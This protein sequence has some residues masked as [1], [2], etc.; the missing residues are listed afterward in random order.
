MLCAVACFPL[1]QS[2]VKELVTHHDMSFVQAIWGRYF[3]HLLLVPLFFPRT[4]TTIRDGHHRRIQ[5]IRGLVLF[6]STGFSFLGLRFVPLPE[7]TALTFIAPVI[8]TILAA[9]FLHETVGW[10]RWLAVVIG[11]VG[12]L[13]IIR[14]DVQLEW[15]VL[16]PVG[17]ATT[18]AIYQVLTRMVGVHA[19][20]HE[21][22]FYTALVGAAAASVMVPLVWVW[23][24]ATGWM[25]LVGSAL[26]A[27]LGHWCMIMAYGRAEA[28]FI[29]PFAYTELIWATLLGITL[30]GEIPTTSTWI[31][32]GIIVISGLWIGLRTNQQPNK[33]RLKAD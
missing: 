1:M 14:P 23:P 3:F 18:Y 32:A 10:R 28:S 31:G 4:L 25:L 5:V 11:I 12:A 13:V 2:C 33:R 26:A 30:F 17:M 21:S 15:T 6:V 9:L 7:F 20:P 8:V 16:L 19:S 27:A 24:S 22:L 29:A